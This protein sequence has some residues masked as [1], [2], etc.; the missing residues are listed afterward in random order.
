MVAYPGIGK[1]QCKENTEAD[2][3]LCRNGM[4]EGIGQR[5]RQK[6]DCHGADPQDHHKNDR[7][8]NGG[9]ADVQ[10]GKFI[11]DLLD[12]VQEILNA[13]IF[14]KDQHDIQKRHKPEYKRRKNNG[15]DIVD[16]LGAE[17]L[18]NTVRR[19]EKHISAFFAQILVIIEDGLHRHVHKAEDCQE[20]ESDDSVS[21]GFIHLSVQTDQKDHFQH[22]Q[23]SQHDVF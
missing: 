4:K 6:R 2:Q 1:V 12:L 5:D 10:I 18:V 7:R 20:C 21:H 16:D 9:R 8:N 14:E 15:K 22:C 11:Q 17:D 19:H 3:S 13:V 23:K